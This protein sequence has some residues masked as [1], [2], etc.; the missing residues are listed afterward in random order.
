MKDRIQRWLGSDHLCDFGGFTKKNSEKTY[1]SS[2]K[3]KN[4]HQNLWYK[5][6]A[7]EKKNE[8]GK[9]TL[10]LPFRCRVPQRE[11]SLANRLANAK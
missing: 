2:P 4:Y 7:A 10:I 8:E 9:K 1:T 11:N 5:N 3:E 6:K